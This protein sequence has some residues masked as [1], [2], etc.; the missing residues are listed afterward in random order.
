MRWDRAK[1]AQLRKSD[2]EFAREARRNHSHN[3]RPTREQRILIKRLARETDTDIVTASLRTKQEA[4]EIIDYL[5]GVR[6]QQGRAD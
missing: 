3:D 6:Q 2:L 1:R 5:L 4:G